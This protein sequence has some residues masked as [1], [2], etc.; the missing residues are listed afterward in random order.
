MQDLNA[1]LL[2]RM[3]QIGDSWK[4]DWTEPVMD[5]SRLYEYRTFYTVPEY[6]AWAK[7][8]PHLAP[9]ID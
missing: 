9:G 6:L 2:R 4:F 5:D 7:K 3:N 8:H 1:R